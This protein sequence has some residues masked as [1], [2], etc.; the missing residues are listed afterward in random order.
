MKKK[1]LLITLMAAI[2]VCALAIFANAAAPMPSKPDIG[3]SFGEVTPIDGFVAPSELY[4]GT[5]ERV[6]LDDGNGNYVT[7][8]TY[9]VT[10]NS[11]TFDF[12]FSKL[13]GAQSIEYSKKSVVMVEIPNGVT[14]ISKSYFAGT[15]N[16]PLC[17]SVQ[18][19]G[20]VTSYGS[21][22]FQTN[23]VIRIVEFLDGTEPVTMGDGMFGGAWNG[24]ANMIGYVRFPNNLVSIGNGTF[25]KTKG[26][27]KVVILGANLQTV[28]TGFFGEGTP[29]ATDTFLYVSDNFFKEAEVFAN[30]FGSE[31]PY[32]DNNLRITVFYTGTQEQAQALADKGLAV[33][34]SGYVWNN[35]KIVSADEYDYDTHKPSVDK[36]IT[37]VY[38]MEKCDVFYGGHS[39][40]GED[41][42]I[43]DN[44]F[45]GFGIGDSCANCG[46]T[47]IKESYGALFTYFGYSY[48]EK[49]IGG[50][51]SMSQ[52]YGV[53]K[54]N[55]EAYE[56]LA[57]TTVAYGVVIASVENPL[58]SEYVGTN[59]VIVAEQW[60]MP[61]NYT[62]VKV[63][64]ITEET[65]NSG[66]VFCM[67]VND[68]GSI[69]YLDGGKTS[70]TASLKSYND[71]VEIKNNEQAA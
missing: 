31:A 15:G 24:G 5:N 14:A 70:D 57:K 12:D 18:V 59:K 32:H 61:L 50:S 2:F 44:Y 8:P 41:S 47:E 36:S 62:D 71:I 16:F 54:E 7:Y 9:Y 68:A 65:A 40:K 45:E 51:F 69:Y 66:V 64:G 6:L 4:V 48:T 53:N 55:I 22:M 30:L 1:F 29:R 3:V 35:L 34:P 56:E 21:Y 13:N 23:S 19:P 43:L 58:S 26:S 11:T 33:Q 52:F 37:I 63:S 25:G 17:L 60:R 27:S 10:K 42:V 38:G 39:F 46:R 49:A 28:G 20:T 67:Y